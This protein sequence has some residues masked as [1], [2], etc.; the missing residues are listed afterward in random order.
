MRNYSCAEIQ[1]FGVFRKMIAPDG[2]MLES[3]VYCDR[4]STF[5]V[6]HPVSALT[7]LYY[8]GC[9]PFCELCEDLE[10]INKG[11]ISRQVNVEAWPQVRISVSLITPLYYQSFENF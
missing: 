3:A 1:N 10:T 2:K 8:G 4:L 7:Y 5:I 6:F 9:P 11:S